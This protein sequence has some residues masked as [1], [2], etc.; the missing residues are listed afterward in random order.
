[1]SDILGLRR[2]SEKLIWADFCKKYNIIL[3]N[4]NRY[5]KWYFILCIYAISACFHL[6]RYIHLVTYK[7]TRD[8]NYDNAVAFCS[9]DV[10]IEE[11][12]QALGK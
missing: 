7:E 5:R 8:M 1:M 3:L 11:V 10:P 2:D 4:V 6:S 9:N 12:V